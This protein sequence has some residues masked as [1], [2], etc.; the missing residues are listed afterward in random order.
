MPCFG[1]GSWSSYSRDGPDPPVQGPT[2]FMA[3]VAVQIPVFRDNRVEIVN[4]KLVKEDNRSSRRVTRANRN[5]WA[6]G[7]TMCSPLAYANVTRRFI[8]GL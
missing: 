2:A 7:N 4:R 3:R 5:S 8:K 1:Q 6:V